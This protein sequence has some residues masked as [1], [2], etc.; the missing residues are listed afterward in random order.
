MGGFKQQ[1]LTH[2]SESQKSEIKVSAGLR[3]LE[4]PREKPSHASLGFWWSPTITGIPWLVDASLQFLPLSSHGILPVSLSTFLSS[5]KNTSH[6][7]RA[8]PKPVWS[9]LNHICEDPYPKYGH[10]EVPRGTTW[11]YLSGGTRSNPRPLP[12]LTGTSHT[13]LWLPW[14]PLDP[15]CQKG[16]HLRAFT[17]AVPSAMNA[18]PTD[19]LASSFS[20]LGLSSKCYCHKEAPCHPRNSGLFP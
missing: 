6:W 16:F 20:S 15:K 13:M 7:N 17:S 11:T 12:S 19:L 5:F 9:H 14:L 4:A 1:T 18:Q 10:I 2:S 3:P 8:H